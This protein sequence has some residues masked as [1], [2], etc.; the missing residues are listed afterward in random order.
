MSNFKDYNNTSYQS[1]TVSIGTWIVI[2]IGLAIPLLNIIVMIG[3]AFSS[4][5]ETINNYG[6]A[7]LI[8]LGISFS[9]ALLFGGCSRI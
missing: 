2:L 3:L 9:L 5:N 6:K 4:D 1:D 8:L 7:L